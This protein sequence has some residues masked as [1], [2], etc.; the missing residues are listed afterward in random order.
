MKK[1]A[2][3]KLGDFLC[4]VCGEQRVKRFSQKCTSCKSLGGGDAK[5]YEGLAVLKRV[6]SARLIT[7]DGAEV[8]VDKNGK[9]VTDHGYDLENDP[10]GWKRT[11]T[12]KPK[13]TII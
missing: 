2:F 6:P 10:R 4:I 5:K 8:F 12:Q 3:N 9:E 7:G 13:R 11:G 1:I